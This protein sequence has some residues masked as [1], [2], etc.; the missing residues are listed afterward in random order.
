M[1]TKTFQIRI[2]GNRCIKLICTGTQ[3]TTCLKPHTYR[4]VQKFQSA[5]RQYGFVTAPVKQRIVMNWV[6]CLLMGLLKRPHK[7][8]QW[9]PEQTYCTWRAH[10]NPGSP[11]LRAARVAASTGPNISKS[12]ADYWCRI[13]GR[14][15]LSA[16]DLVKGYVGSDDLNMGRYSTK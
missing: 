1:F 8:S 13:S 10:E 12:C 15:Q 2:T 3:K 5:L 16:G 6:H 11:G 7:Y 4:I 9:L 14:V